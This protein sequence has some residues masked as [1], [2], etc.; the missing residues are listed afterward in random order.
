MNDFHSL[1]FKHI[2]D[3]LDATKLF[4]SFAEIGKFVLK[5]YF[6]SILDCQNNIDSDRLSFVHL[7]CSSDRW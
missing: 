4:S 2:F 6:Y 7:K 1:N 3:Q 5:K